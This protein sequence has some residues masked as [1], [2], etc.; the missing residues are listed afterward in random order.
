M[1]YRVRHLTR[2]AYQDGVDLGMHVLHL[3]PRPLAWQKVLATSLR[4]VPCPAHQRESVDHFGNRVTW[5]SVDQ[6]HPGLDLL[7]ELLV[8]VHRPVPPDA[9]QTPRW[10]SVAAAAAS[11][12]PEAWCASE[13]LFE[14]PMAPHAAAVTDYAAPSF[15]PGRPVLDGLLE[16]NRRINRDF[17]FRA[18]VTTL[19]TAPA[20]VLARREGVCQ[21]FTH[22]MIAALRG[23]GLPARYM[24]GYIRTRPP[25]GMERR[26]GSDQSH[27]WVG[28]WI[29]ARRGWV[30]L[31]PTND[32][33]VSEEHVV[34]AWGRDYGDVTPV[35]GVL[36]GG[37]AHTLSVSVDL[38][39][40]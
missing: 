24:S 27:A 6:P 38:E 29:G 20:Q 40:A 39:P 17:V 28:C 3:R 37:G 34:L 15:P 26:V 30:E 18:G 8:D 4:A 35:R 22:V 1:I 19:T 13:F 32:L 36:L 7:A 2:Y 14:S 33:I 12:G 16:L 25:P 23:L 5:L 11:G 31:D 21:D 10:E 9:I